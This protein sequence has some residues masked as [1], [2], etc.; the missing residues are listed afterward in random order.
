MLATAVVLLLALFLLAIP[1]SIA[2]GLLGLSLTSLFSPLPLHRAL[3]EV[4]W[5]ISIEFILFAVPLYILMGEILLRSGVATR[6]YDAM[7]KWLSWLPGGLIHSNIGA[8]ALFAATSGSSIATAATIGTIA[9]PEQKKNGY[10]E[11]LF[12]GSIAGGGTLGILIPPSINMI[13]YALLS[14]TSIP[15]LYLASFIPGLLLAVLFSVTILLAVLWRPA[16]GGTP[17]VVTWRERFQSLPHLLPPLGLFIVVIGSIYAGVATPSESA[18]L[19]VVS[20]MLLALFHK[21]LTIDVLRQSVEGTLRITGMT[22]LIVFGAFFL[23]IV[24]STLGITSAAVAYVG[25]FELTPL[26][27]IIILC[28]FY[29]ILGAFMDELAML[30]TTAPLVVPIVIAQGIDPI[31][32][33]VL[34]MVL[35]QTGM[36]APPFGIN[37]FVVQSVRGRGALNDIVIGSAPFLLAMLVMVVLLV[38]FPGIAMWL[39][40]ALK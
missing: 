25:S 20:A 17:I 18:A 37:L 7:A 3:G 19:G 32:F 13:I 38:A 16:W 24:L 36:I 28:V 15:Q 27:T 4:A 34:M 30:V 21:R 31:W 5:S 12:L 2:L 6:M 35:S 40:G 23:S 9:L 22:M 10:N 33:G 39:P 11:R 29:I 14:E 26:G 8:C 1:I